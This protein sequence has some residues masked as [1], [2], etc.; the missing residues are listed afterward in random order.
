MAIV[1]VLSIVVLLVLIVLLV[2]APLRQAAARR[3]GAVEGD[4]DNLAA[5]DRARDELEAARE[6]KYREIRDAELD[7]R[8]GKLS[9][10]DYRELDAELRAEAL[11]IL[12]ELDAGVRPRGASGA[13]SR[14]RRTGPRRRPS[15]D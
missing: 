14:S 3:A 15:S 2:G 10:R 5:G 1:I 12:D 4:T 9:E 6:A 11:V 8:T 7:F 13:R